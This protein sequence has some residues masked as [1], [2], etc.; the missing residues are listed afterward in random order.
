M[1][2]IIIPSDFPKNKLLAFWNLENLENQSIIPADFGN[3]LL[4]AYSNQYSSVIGKVKNGFYFDGGDWEDY[5][6]WT[7]DQLWNLL[8]NPISFSV[9][10]WVK[11][12]QNIDSSLFGNAFGSMGFN[13]DYI[14]DS[15]YWA[16]NVGFAFRITKGVYDWNS[17]YTQ[18]NNISINQWYH[19]VGT[20]DHQVATMKLYVNSI[21]KS[22]M[23]NVLI[24][25]NSEPNW[26]G[27]AV[28]GTVING[29]K[30]YGAKSAFDAI[31]F[32]NKAL[33]QNEISSL[34]NDGKGRQYNINNIS[35][36]KQNLGG[37]KLIAK[38]FSPKDL[39]N[40]Q[41][42]LKSDA[43][44][45]LETITL[46]YVSQVI[47]TESG[48]STSD[49]TYTRSSGDTTQFD[50]PNG[51]YIY[52]DGGAWIIYD[53]TIESETYIN[54]SYE[55]DE[56]SWEEYNESGIPTAVNT[57][58]NLPPFQGVTSWNDQSG[59][60]KNFTK[61]ISNTGYPTYSS[62]A[63]LFTAT[64]TYGDSNA[65]ILALPSS[66]LNFTTPYTLITVVKAGANNSCVFSK[67]NNDTKRRKY[68]ISINGGVIYSLEGNGD[69]SFSH[70]T[71][72]GDD[73]DIKRLIITQYSSTNFGI[74]R[75]NGAQVASS[76]NNNTINQ[77]NNASI[78]IGASPFQEGTG[79]NAEASTEMYVYEILFYN[80]ALT[81]DEIKKL[82][83]Y[84]NNK[85]LI[86]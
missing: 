71:G 8:T 69:V 50:G 76:N 17:I 44:V 75:Y 47:I 12:P 16:P 59:N 15:E 21:L 64:A 86:Y 5:G 84:L 10:F 72:T 22:T 58:T 20:Y 57:S 38:Q 40:L 9:S 82:E 68:Q 52:W 55:L 63:V 26:H 43:G 83:D 3:F 60:G 25:A 24:G 42:W 31:G 62:N 53:A 66:D 1:G 7:N 13:F 36:K 33:N 56:E 28:N 49:G 78:F 74:M 51:N 61:S 70:D 32:W 19:L 79:Y 14:Y 11:K 65:S 39:I 80:R 23:T 73:V 6:L 29:G 67:S 4:N 41:V 48:A 30:V 37:G 35:I 34:Y 2:S 46:S 85:Y 77:T 81:L 45:I 27:F 54:Y 18:E